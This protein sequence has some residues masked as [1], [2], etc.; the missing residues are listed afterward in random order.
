MNFVT[1]IS[2]TLDS[3]NRRL[4]KFRRLGKKD[5][6]ECLQA[7]PYGVDANPIA[8]VIA[9]YSPTLQNGKPV[10]LTYLNKNQIAEPGEHR[11]FSTDSNGDVVMA[12]HLK[13]DGTV[14]FG[15]DA[16]NMIR[17]IPLN[18]A[19]NSQASSINVELVKIAAAI[20]AIVPGSYTPSTI[21]IDI[22]GSKIDEIKTS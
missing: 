6:Q 19:L 10:I 12:L 4:I 13:N 14:E 20:N 18:T 21:S 17:F 22:S 3:L 2:T 11:I 15:G 8:E 9:I 5:I 1:I 16:D 7:A